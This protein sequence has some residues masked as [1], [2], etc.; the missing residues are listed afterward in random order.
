MF[1]AQPNEYWASFFQPRNLIAYAIQP[2]IIT[3]THYFGEPNYISDTENTQILNVEHFEE[4]N[5]G[6]N[7]KTLQEVKQ[8]IEL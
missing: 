1:D 8:H 3:P 6:Q 7:E 2:A 4:P 5:K